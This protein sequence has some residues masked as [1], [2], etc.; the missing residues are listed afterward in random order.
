MAGVEGGCGRYS[1]VGRGE[2]GDKA[3]GGEGDEQVERVERVEQAE[4]AQL[5][6]DGRLGTRLFDAVPLDRQHRELGHRLESWPIPVVG[7]DRCDGATD[8]SLGT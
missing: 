7:R 6:R 3:G 8:Q 1:A 2:R 4:Q 5:R